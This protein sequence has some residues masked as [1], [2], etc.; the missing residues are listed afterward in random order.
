MSAIEIILSLTR[1]V[2]LMCYRGQNKADQSLSDLTLK[3]RMR[4]MWCL[5][6][7]YHFH[8]LGFFNNVSWCGLIGGRMIFRLTPWGNFCGHCYR[9]HSELWVWE[10]KSVRQNYLLWR[11]NYMVCKLKEALCQ[12]CN[13]ILHGRKSFK[14]LISINIHQSRN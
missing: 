2:H 12:H 6:P 1:L 9:C 7:T 11:Y 14:L 3:N 8:I 13:Q 5:E 10:N 4:Q